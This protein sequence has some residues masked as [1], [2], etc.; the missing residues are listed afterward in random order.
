LFFAAIPFIG[1][2]KPL[3][4]LLS[5]SA[6]VIVVAIVSKLTGCGLSATIFLGDIKSYEREGIGMISRAEMDL[7]V[8]G[9]GV[10]PLV[11]ST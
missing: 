7:I 11:S 1:I 2:Y 8:A 6:V 3:K 10:S 5:L 9:C 4:I